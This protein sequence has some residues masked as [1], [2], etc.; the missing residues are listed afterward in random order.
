MLNKQ[1][2]IDFIEQKLSDS[3]GDMVQVMHSDTNAE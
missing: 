2:E 1:I 3:F